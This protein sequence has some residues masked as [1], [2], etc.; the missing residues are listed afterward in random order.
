MSKL[1][2]VDV[3]QILAERGI[4]AG[5]GDVIAALEKVDQQAHFEDEREKLVYEEW[6]M[7]SPINGVPAEE[8]IAKREMINPDVHA[9]YLIKDAAT[10]RVIYFQYTRPRTGGPIDPSEH[11]IETIANEHMDDFAWRRARDGIIKDVIR[12]L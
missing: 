10:G 11:D 6:D 1:D 9:V 3:L 2:D 7:A 12:E 4:Q 8:M 5:M